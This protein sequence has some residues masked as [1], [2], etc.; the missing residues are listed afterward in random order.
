[1]MKRIL[2]IL[3]VTLIFVSLISVMLAVTGRLAWERYYSMLTVEPEESE[4]SAPDLFPETDALATDGDGMPVLSP[5]RDVFHVLLVGV[6]DPPDT[7]SCRADAVLLL[8]VNRKSRKIV[9]CSIL[10]DLLVSVEGHGQGKLNSAY[11]YGKEELLRATL[12]Q[13]FNLEI[14][15]Y[16][17]VDFRAFEGVVDALDGVSVPL[18]PR[19]A[20]A[21]NR[22]CREEKTTSAILPESEGTYRL[23]GA[24]ALAFARDRG[25]ATGDFDRTRR[26]RL[27]L[28]SLLNERKNA[29]LISLLAAADG[30]LPYISTNLSSEQLRSIV[31][32]LPEWMEYTFVPES[33][34]G[35]GNFSFDTHR[36]TSVIRIDRRKIITDLHEK[37]YE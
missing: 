4:T 31:T 35:D 17:T 14:P 9:L 13:N 21:V 20:A 32:E 11:F 24:Q 5:T 19:E 23:N 36:G 8:S 1:M 27:L 37:L 6:D 25:S 10:R 3:W 34:P 12:R 29:S 22:I 7:S 28:S 26:Q 2:T 30:I 16:V 33:V 18:S 15:Y